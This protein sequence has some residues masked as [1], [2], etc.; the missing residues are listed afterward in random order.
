ME[1]TEYDRGQ[2]SAEHS[3]PVPHPAKSDNNFVNKIR[4]EEFSYSY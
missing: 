3:P 1:M 2:C 4:Y